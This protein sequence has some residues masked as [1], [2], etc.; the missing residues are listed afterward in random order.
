ME[1][2]IS[3]GGPKSPLIKVDNA[4]GVIE[5][6]GRSNPENAREF[7]MPLLDWIKEYQQHPAAETV[8]NI[9]LEHF[10]TSSSKFLLDVMR[11][12][13]QIYDA[14]NKC[15]V[16]WY[17]EDDDEEMLESAEVYEAMTGLL[18][19]KIGYPEA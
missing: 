4:T 11:T 5:L 6:S 19:N 16:N 17:Y 15:T 1:K 10:N 8:L 7:Y 18:I 2:V 12:L 3:P 9:N 14:G 13:K